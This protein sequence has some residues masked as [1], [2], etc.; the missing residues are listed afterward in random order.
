MAK[1]DSGLFKSMIKPVPPLRRD[2]H[3]FEEQVDGQAVIGF[4]D[5]RAYA[6]PHFA[7]PADSQQ[8]LSLIN[9]EFSVQQMLM[10]CSEEI[11][12]EDLLDYIQF[13]DSHGVLDSDYYRA[14]ARKTDLDYESADVH[15]SVTAGL[16]YSADESELTSYLDKMF[17]GFEEDT[18]QDH[19]AT[20]AKALFAPHIDPRIG[21]SSYVKAFS[22]IRNLKPK[23]V[24]MMGTSHYSGLFGSHY[25]FKPF[26]GVD[27]DF[28]MVNGRIPSSTS[29]FEQLRKTQEQVGL[30]SLTFQDRAHRIEHSLELH[31]LFLNYIWDHDFEIIPVLVGSF[32]ELMYMENSSLE[33]EVDKMTGIISDE[34]YND[35]DTFILVSGDLSHIGKKFGD[36]QAAS[37]MIEQVN[38]F[39]QE[40]LDIA[41]DNREDDLLKLMKSN[42]DAYRICG[43][44]PLMSLMKSMPELKGKRISYDVWDEKERES[45]VTFG[46]ILYS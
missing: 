39:D 13:L 30:Q 33:M 11:K 43:F 23:R 18:E 41:A 14:K 37:A 38:A 2:I 20:S 42:F 25:D 28:D 35:E 3:L 31:A 6:T 12:A 8:L 34:F 32:D 22:A 44:S 15:E 40:F 10:Y 26:I 21:I 9:G 7:L 17:E 4:H 46:S 5:E 45:A 1:E 19:S 36:E 24:L 16:S 27:K 29:A